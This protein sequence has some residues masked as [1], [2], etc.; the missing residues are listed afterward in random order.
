M[1]RIGFLLY[2]AAPHFR[3]LAS[4]G[5][6]KKSASGADLTE[7]SGSVTA[8]LDES[9]HETFPVHYRGHAKQVGS[10]DADAEPEV[11]Y[12]DHAKHIGDD[13]V[14][15][16]ARR[17]EGTSSRIFMNS[18]VELHQEQGSDHFEFGTVSGDIGPA[19]CV[20]PRW[21]INNHEMQPGDC[22]VKPSK[23]H[24]IADFDVGG[25]EGVVPI[26]KAK[27]FLEAFGTCDFGKDWC[28]HHEQM[29]R[30]C[31]YSVI[32]QHYEG[33]VMQIEEP[34]CTS[35]SATQSPG[36]LRKPS[37]LAQVTND[38]AIKFLQKAQENPGDFFLAFFAQTLK[39]TEVLAFLE[40]LKTES[41]KP[42]SERSEAVRNFL[43]STPWTTT[44]I[45]GLTAK[46]WRDHILP[47]WEKSVP[48][49][50]Q[51]LKRMENQFVHLLYG[52]LVEYNSFSMYKYYTAP[53]T[54]GGPKIPL[55]PV[56]DYAFFFL[57]QRPLQSLTQRGAAADILPPD[58]LPRVSSM[59]HKNLTWDMA[60]EFSATASIGTALSAWILAGGYGDSSTGTDS[61]S[62][63]MIRTTYDDM[64]RQLFDMK[65]QLT[66][67]PTQTG[68]FVAFAVNVVWFHGDA[69]WFEHNFVLGV[70]GASLDNSGPTAFV[71]D[72]SRL[73]DNEFYRYMP[74]QLRKFSL[75]D[76]DSLLEF[77]CHMIDYSCWNAMT[78]RDPDREDSDWLYTEE[79]RKK[80]KEDLAA[81]ENK[82][83]SA[84]AGAQMDKDYMKGWKKKWSELALR[85]E[86]PDKDLETPGLGYPVFRKIWRLPTNTKSEAGQKSMHVVPQNTPP[87]PSLRPH[88]KRFRSV[89][90]PVAPAAPAT[91]TGV[92]P[93][94]DPATST[95]ATAAVPA[96][97]TGVAPAA[98]P[99][100]S[101]VAASA[102][103]AAT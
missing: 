37:D 29:V 9:A 94:A 93:A 63:A 72:N 55:E 74:L 47:L 57:A 26:G 89:P 82:L 42:K 40:R 8:F 76:L 79:T 28:W 96:T 33:P 51:L 92:A 70:S 53:I 22:G 34:V 59:L 81:N 68:M 45:K 2:P 20:S 86:I 91:P 73:D 39:E 102:P 32:R 10:I 25:E 1:M 66:K 36:A 62:I 65:Q 11:T 30:E 88:Q 27:E 71:F 77:T 18:N 69:H 13:V 19:P 95:V 21:T 97:P 78:V 85:G 101:T 100:T 12:T 6:E 38:T 5:E 54:T 16:Q 58:F 103:E 67:T 84:E 31:P 35:R 50:K 41:R 44:T 24:T 14:E 60:K 56:P 52:K 43:S 90:S 15:H 7:D 80:Q 17:A 98:D 46:Q 4:G 3:V 48:F 99:A 23:D 87:L 61:R 75:E 83:R 64:W 49:A